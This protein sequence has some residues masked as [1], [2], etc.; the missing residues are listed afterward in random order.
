MKKRTVITNTPI[1]LPFS[2]TILYGFLLYYFKI[3]GLYW[4]IFITVYSIIWIAG[5]IAKFNEN[6]IDLD[7]ISKPTATKSKFHERLEQLAKERQAK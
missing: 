7:D 6:K 3:D 5:I 4:G 2:S 1:K